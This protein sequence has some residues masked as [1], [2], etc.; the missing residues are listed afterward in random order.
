MQNKDP[1][2][3]ERMIFNGT[4]DSLPKIIEFR[5]KDALF[6]FIKTKQKWTDGNGVNQEIENRYPVLLCGPLLEENQKILNKEIIVSVKGL[7]K[8]NIEPYTECLIV[9][10][11]FSFVKIIDN[12]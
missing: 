4:I 5:K 12:Q 7:F 3:K 9:D 10:D 6:F 8:T 1:N 2:W 11:S